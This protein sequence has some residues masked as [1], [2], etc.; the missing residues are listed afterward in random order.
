MCAHM[1]LVAEGCDSAETHIHRR[2]ALA[3][4]RSTVKLTVFGYMYAVTAYTHMK[5]A[6]SGRN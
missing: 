6:R 2:T 3:K 5:Y 1:R 4:Y